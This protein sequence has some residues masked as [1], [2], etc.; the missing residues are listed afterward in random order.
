MWDKDNTYFIILFMAAFISVYVFP[1]LSY[2]LFIVFFVLAYKSNKDYLWLAFI[3]LLI[4]APGNLFSGGARDEEMRLPL[5]SLGPGFSF[6]TIQMF[7]FV[8]LLKYFPYHEF[9]K[10]IFRKDLTVLFIFVVFVF[11]YSLIL[12]MSINNII[13]SL[14]EL[15]NW[16]WVIIL[17]NGLNTP[18]DVKKLC[19]LLFPFVFIVLAAQIYVLITGQQID[20]LLRGV[21]P[22]RALLVVEEGVER[23]SRVGGSPYLLLIS[24][25]MS[26]YFLF[27]NRKRYFPTVYLSLVIASCYLSI[28]LTA[29]R[30][31]IIA[32]SVML[33]LAL[34][35]QSNIHNIMKIIGMLVGGVVIIWITYIVFPNIQIQ[36]DNVVKRMQTVEELAQGD[37]TAGGTLQRLDQRAPRVLEKFKENPIFGWGMSDEYRN[38]RDSHIGHHNLLL[39]V[40]LIGYI[41]V[42][43][44]FIKWNL[45]ISRSA[46]LLNRLKPGIGRP[47]LIFNIGLIAIFIIHS[48]ST[49]MIGVHLGH[50][51]TRYILL[52][53]LISV[54]SVFVNN[55][56]P[57]YENTASEVN[58]SQLY[59]NFK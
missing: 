27:N 54:Y 33:G 50:P 1:V 56:L 34:L 8:F 17:I 7:M 46:I 9:N 22:H 6:G 39:N 45:I 23:V 30:G 2:P 29:T 42:F 37:V 24:I 5:F 52:A 13:R 20:G 14:R 38:Y 49:Q 41:I 12:G 43:A 18:E 55:D 15:L 44:Y 32:F 51:P 28:F 11:I 10:N 26:L 3:I 57:E 35:T 58:D 59:G 40:G 16:T 36:L 25:V 53:V 47:Y 31:W 48:T 4:D 19:K 21:D